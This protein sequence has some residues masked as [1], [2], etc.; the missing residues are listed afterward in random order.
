MKKESSV[1]RSAGDTVRRLPYRLP[2]LGTSL[3]PPQLEGIV[4]WLFWKSRRERGG[5]GGGRERERDGRTDRQTDRDKQTDRQTEKETEREAEGQT[6]TQT[7]I[8]TETE[9]NKNARCVVQPSTQRDVFH[10]DWLT[11]GI[12][13][14]L[15]KVPASS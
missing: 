10:T 7:E 8:E 11:F 2:T 4:S 5:G 12:S 9:R 14:G 13:P 1:S 15:V 3:T 6:R